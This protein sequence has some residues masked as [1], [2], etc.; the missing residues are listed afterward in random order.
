MI[1]KKDQLKPTQPYFVLD[2]KDFYQEIYLQQGISHFYSYKIEED[3]PLRIVPD[4][5]IDFFFEYGEEGMQ[6]FV[7]GTSLEYFC[8]ERKAT[9]EVFVVR[10]MPG[11]Q[12]WMLNCR[13]R[14]LLE[15]RLPLELVLKRDASRDWLEQIEEEKDFYQRIRIF[16]ESFTR[17]ENKSSV[18]LG[19]EALVWSV[20]QMIYD[21]GGNIKISHLQENTG[22]SSRYI[23]KIFLEEMGFSPKTFCQI[24]RFQKALEI[25]NSGSDSSMTDIALA[26]GYYDQPQ[27][28]H[29]FTRYAGRTPG[30]YRKLIE[31][32]QYQSRIRQDI[33]D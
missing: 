21:S 24:L 12:P 1:Q 33:Q 5:C 16:L 2:T 20:K 26:L 8:Q 15:H 4:G 10:F 32:K 3:M 25:L 13:M 29:D 28:I 11:A 23:N 7:C 9:N 31:S 14:E 6:S 22:Y 19:K 30:K 18:L 27:F 17:E